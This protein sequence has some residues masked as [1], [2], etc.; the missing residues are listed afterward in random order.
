MSTELDDLERRGTRPEELAG[1]LEP[2]LDLG[3]P[4]LEVLNAWRAAVTSGNRAAQQAGPAAYGISPGWPEPMPRPV[5]SRP[6]VRTAD[7]E[8]MV[9]HRPPLVERK[10]S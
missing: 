4:T 7:L 10:E 5:L 9:R 3:E 1:G 8:K 6:D 2:R